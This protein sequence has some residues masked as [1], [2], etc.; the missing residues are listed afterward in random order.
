MAF[1]PLPLSTL[2]RKPV[3]RRTHVN[4]GFLPTASVH[5]IQKASVSSYS[6]Q[7]W[8]SSHCLCPP[9]S[10]SQCFVVLMSTMAF[11][12]LPPSTLFRKPVFRRTHVNDGFLPTASVHPI[13]K[14]SVS[15]YS[16]QRWLSSHCLRPPY[17]ERQCF[18][19]RLPQRRQQHEHWHRALR[20]WL[21]WWWWAG[22][23]CCTGR[24]EESQ[25]SPS[26]GDLRFIALAALCLALLSCDSSQ[27][28]CAWFVYV[29]WFVFSP[30]LHG[31]IHSAFNECFHFDVIKLS[32]PLAHR[33]GC[34]DQRWQ[35]IMFLCTAWFILFRTNNT[36]FL[37]I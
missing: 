23:W 1:F 15:S 22:L 36:C 13:Q 37:L 20:W 31:R 6:C 5:P 2:F 14:A 7:R 4:D 16:C 34:K 21:R 26:E 32:S 10:E 24:W 18:W 12:P 11:F 35:H 27:L 8:L 3:F 25:V 17:S 30:G 33:M 28:S 9:Y 29:V 19:Q